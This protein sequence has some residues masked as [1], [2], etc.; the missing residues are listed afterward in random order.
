MGLRHTIGIVVPV[1]VGALVGNAAGGLVA[2]L[3]ALNVAVGD[4]SDSYPR[5]VRRMALASV[6]CALAVFAGGLTG[7]SYAV[8]PILAAAAFV[9][10]ITVSLGTAQ[11]DLGNI[12]LV[13]LIVF[14]AKPAPLEQAWTSGAL[15]L[16]GGLFQTGLTAALWPFRRHRPES[17]ALRKLLLELA[18]AASSQAPIAEAPP[19]SRESTEAQQALAG[20]DPRDSVVA[21]R[22]LALL[23]QAERIRLSLL[24]LWRVRVRIGRE[25]GTEAITAI[26]ERFAGLASEVLRTAADLLVAPARAKSAHP[27]VDLSVPMAQAARELR[28]ACRHCPANVAA[29]LA[30]A[31]SQVDALAGQLRSVQFLAAQTTRS[32]VAEFERQEAAQPWHLRFAGTVSTLN[33]NLRLESPAFRH[34]VRLAV[35]VVV[36]EMVP[37]V[38]HW[39]RPYWVPMTIALVLKPDFTTTFSRGWQ[40]LLG[41]LVGLVVATAIFHYL[42]PSLALQ[43]AFL[44]LFCFLMRAYGPA[45]YGI[46][47]IAVTAVVVFLFAVTGVRPAEVV[48]ARGL[49][50]LA[51]GVLAL[52]AYGLWPTWERTLAPEAA[53]RML[54]AYRAYFQAVRDAYLR[55]EGSAGAALDRARLEARIARSN[56]EASVARLRAEPGTPAGRIARFDRILADSHRLVH[57]L[58]SLEGG[59]QTSR[60]VPSR[61]AFGAFAND[62][63][64]TLYFLAAA[65]RGVPLPDLP[66]LRED[67]HTLVES[68]DAGVPRYALVNIEA[69]RIVNSLN[70]LADD[71]RP[72]VE[73]RGVAVI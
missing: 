27:P 48:M 2:G 1:I 71:I 23:S 24:L 12:T 17:L 39:G 72:L 47:A 28:D 62:A 45:N 59:L 53:A 25:S 5:R 46:L 56:L 73:Q 35:C 57:A 55:Q 19:A 31:R 26:L 33:A 14:S 54:D 70:T 3:G 63:D 41:T 43:I 69:D 29:M 34:G 20:V 38:L 7:G 16:A 40:R 52:T 37:R 21:E 18:Q 49:N 66:D 11:A 67:H 36:G 22:Y 8:D 65:L 61:Q 42:H 44:A 32:G 30:D 60:P 58:M 51:G 13:T 15:A 6:L 64:R 50:T 68:G 9:A 4:G 10:G